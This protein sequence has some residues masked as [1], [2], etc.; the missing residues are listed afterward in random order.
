[1]LAFAVASI[2]EWINVKKIYQI[3]DNLINESPY[4]EYFIMKIN[5]TDCLFYRGRVRKILSAASCQYMI[6]HF[7]IE[8][9]IVIGTCA[10]VNRK[11]HELDIFQF[12]SACQSDCMVYELT[13]QLCKG[14][15]ELYCYEKLSFLKKGKISAMDKTLILKKD[16]EMLNN[17]NIDCDDM[18]SAA[19]AM[20]CSI[21]SLPCTVIK[22]ISDFANGIENYNTQCD[23]YIK[24]TAII[25]DR[26][27]N[28]ILPLIID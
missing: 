17:E 7:D 16:E 18:E 27:C 11:H 12:E 13:G 3:N 14:E 23:K 19:V 21:H 22:G 5:H 25:I 2:D 4:G 28:E 9:I 15:V 24:N 1:M 26:I 20:V 8:R 6:D 10:G